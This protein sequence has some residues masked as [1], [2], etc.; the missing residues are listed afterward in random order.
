L[1]DTSEYFFFFFFAAADLVA[2][3]QENKKKIALILLD[4]AKDI[5]AR[6]GVMVSYILLTVRY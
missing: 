5:C 2:S 6:H 3:I 1:Y 4:K